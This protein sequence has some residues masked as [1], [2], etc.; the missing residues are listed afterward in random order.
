MSV[1]K[2]ANK[3]KIMYKE[4]DLVENRKAVAIMYHGKEYKIETSTTLKVTGVQDEIIQVIRLSDSLG[5]IYFRPLD[6]R[7]VQK[8]I[9]K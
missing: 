6:V 5:P 4:N 3:E 9:A 7:L 8:K 1:V 2:R